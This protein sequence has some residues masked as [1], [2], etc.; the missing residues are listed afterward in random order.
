ME[1]IKR[2]VHIGI[3]FFQ[4]RSLRELFETIRRSL[5][6]LDTLYIYTY[7][8]DGTI[9]K[10]PIDGC[11]NIKKASLQELKELSFT[12][13]PISWEF[14][15]HE[16]DGVDHCFIAHKNGDICHVSWI[17]FKGDQNRIIDLGEKEAEIK[18]CLTL[19]PYRGKGIYPKVLT[20]ICDYL[21][22]KGLDRVF[23]AVDKNNVPSI[24][25]IRKAG[26]KPITKI[27]LLKIM[28]IQLNKRFSS[29][30]GR[31]Y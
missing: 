5:F 23:I 4:G 6:R 11:Y 16:F 8:L 22:Y 30:S 25:G 21:K 24:K 2:F 29:R 19:P 26:F 15:C 28:G 13:E 10:Y 20:E 18:Y 27:K 14:C 17:Y 7:S 1:R 9:D 31:K 12:P 3:R